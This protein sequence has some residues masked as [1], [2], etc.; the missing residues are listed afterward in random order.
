MGGFNGA[1]LLSFIC[2]EET[3]PIGA[4]RR[5]QARASTVKIVAGVAAAGGL[6]WLVSQAVNLTDLNEKLQIEQ[7]VSVVPGSASL[8]FVKFQINLVLKN[9]TAGSIS[10]KGPA[11]TAYFNGNEVATTDT[12]SNRNYNIS[13]F[14]QV[15][16]APVIMT[17]SA[18]SGGAALVNYLLHVG[19]SRA[20]KLE[21]R[22]LTL[23]NNS[24]PY[25]KSQVVNV[26]T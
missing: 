18:L 25:V 24:I 15:T 26:L 2:V 4:R 23:I 3:T 16:L 8:L 7:R 20:I 6:L 13:A 14:S 11:V 1:T 19:T 22:A 5:A 9:P 12:I 17:V 21:M 10:V